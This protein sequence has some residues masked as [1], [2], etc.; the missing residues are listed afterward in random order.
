MD[1]PTEKTLLER[2]KAGKVREGTI[3]YPPDQVPAVGDIVTFR[4]ATWAFG[5]P[6]RVPNGDWFSVTLTSVLESPMP[7]YFGSTLWEL[8]WDAV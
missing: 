1:V 2:I 3:P 6:S 8:Q 7:R 5:I 4:E